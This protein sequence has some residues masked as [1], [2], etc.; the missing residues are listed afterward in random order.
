MSTEQSTSQSGPFANI[1][2]YIRENQKSLMIIGGVA[3]ALVLGFIAYLKFYKQPKEIEAQDNMWKAQYYFEIDSFNLAINGTMDPKTGESYPGFL[4]IADEYSG[5]QAGHLANYYLGVSYLNLG[6]F[7]LAIEALEK[8]EFSDQIVSALAI[9]ALGDAYMEKGDIE[10]AISKYEE[11]A[12]VSKNL[13]TSPLFL[14]KAAMALEDMGNHAKA[15]GY[16]ETILTEYEDSDEGR[17][18]EKYIARAK[19]R[20]GA[21]Q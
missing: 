9:G 3:V 10:T 14:K 7:D 8:T 11:A 20:A 15:L 1:E 18:I 21:A 4:T 17:D 16:Y 6:Q 13:F 12:E 19:N 2:S 5:T